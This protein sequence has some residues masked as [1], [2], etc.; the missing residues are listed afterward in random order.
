MSTAGSVAGSYAAS[1]THSLN[2]GLSHNLARKRPGS[3]N[4]AEAGRKRS[5]QRAVIRTLREMPTLGLQFSGV[6]LGSNLGSP[7]VVDVF[8]FLKNIRPPRFMRS[9]RDNTGHADDFAPCAA[10]D[11]FVQSDAKMLRLAQLTHHPLFENFQDAE[12][13]LNTDSEL[14]AMQEL[15]HKCALVFEENRHTGETN[16]HH[17]QRRRDYESK[18]LNCLQITNENM[19]LFKPRDPAVSSIFF[20]Q[21]SMDLLSQIKVWGDDGGFAGAGQCSTLYMLSLDHEGRS[22]PAPLLQVITLLSQGLR[23]AW[24]ANDCQQWPAC[25]TH[26]TELQGFHTQKKKLSG[27]RISTSDI[28]RRTKRRHYDQCLDIDAELHEKLMLHNEN[29]ESQAHVETPITQT[30]NQT[31]NIIQNPIAN[32]DKN[33]A[34]DKNDD[35]VHNVSAQHFFD[36]FLVSR[37]LHATD[38]NGIRRVVKVDMLRIH[39][40]FVGIDAIVAIKNCIQALPEFTAPLKHVLE[41]MAELLRGDNS[42]RNIDQLFACSTNDDIVDLLNENGL[43]VALARFADKNNIRLERY[44]NLDSQSRPD[45][46]LVRTFL[47]SVN[48]W[49]RHQYHEILRESESEMSKPNLKDFPYSPFIPSDFQDRNLDLDSSD[50]EPIPLIGDISFHWRSVP[51]LAMHAIAMSFI[52]NATNGIPNSE[53]RKQEM[54]SEYQ[55]WIVEMPY[56]DSTLLYFPV[57]GCD[58]SDGVYMKI[59]MQ[60]FS[61]NERLGPNNRDECGNKIIPLM[62]Q[63]T[64]VSPCI[65]QYVSSHLDVA[66]RSH[67]VCF[68]EDPACVPDRDYILDNYKKMPPNVWSLYEHMRREQVPCMEYAGENGRQ[69]M[70]EESLQ[71]CYGLRAHPFV[72]KYLE[73]VRHSDADM[74]NMREVLGASFRCFYS[75]YEDTLGMIASCCFDQYRYFA[76]YIINLDQHARKQ[77]QM[78]FA[79]INR[80]YSRYNMHFAGTGS[81]ASGLGESD[82]NETN[83]AVRLLQRKLLSKSEDHL[84]T[85]LTAALLSCNEEN[86]LAAMYET[87]IEELDIRLCWWNRLV[88]MNMSLSAAALFGYNVSNTTWGYFIQLSDLGNSMLCVSNEPVGKR[89]SYIRNSKGPSA[90]ADQTAAA[91]S[92]LNKIHG[93]KLVKSQ[94]SNLANFYATA[95]S[96]VTAK[97]TSP[98]G[99]AMLNGSSVIVKAGK[100]QLDRNVTRQYGLFSIYLEGG[101]TDAA[102]TR[103]TTELATMESFL[104][105]SGKSCYMQESNWVSGGSEHKDL[106][107]GNDLPVIERTS[108]RQNDQEP[109]SLKKGGRTKEIAAGVLDHLG[110]ALFPANRDTA[111]KNDDTADIDAVQQCSMAG[112]IRFLTEQDCQRSPLPLLLRMLLRHLAYLQRTMTIPFVDTNTGEGEYTFHLSQQRLSAHIRMSTSQIRRYYFDADETTASRTFDGAYCTSTLNPMHLQALA[113]RAVTKACMIDPSAPPLRAAARDVLHGLLICPPSVNT[114]FGSLYLWLTQAVLDINAMILACFCL[115]MAGFQR[116]CPIRVIAMAA[117]GLSAHFSKD[118]WA[119]YNSLCVFLGRLFFASRGPARDQAAT[120]ELATT[121]SLFPMTE[122]EI[123]ACFA[124]SPPSR[125]QSF[126]FQNPNQNPDQQMNDDAPDDAANKL[127]E[128]EAL[129]EQRN[130]TCNQHHTP[131]VVPAFACET[132]DLPEFIEHRNKRDDFNFGTSNT[133]LAEIFAQ[134]QSEKNEREHGKT[135]AD[136]AKRKRQHFQN[137][138]AFW[139][140]A[141]QGTRLQT[142]LEESND[143]SNRTAIPCQCSAKWYTNNMPSG[144]ENKDKPGG[145]FCDFLLLCG[146]P[147]SSSTLQLVEAI[148]APYLQKNPNLQLKRRFRDPHFHQPI[149]QLSLYKWYAMPTPK[150]TNNN[151]GIDVR[152]GMQVAWMILAQALYTKEWTGPRQTSLPRQEQQH[153]AKALEYSTVVHLRN[154]GHAAGEL[155]FMHAHLRTDKAALPREG[156]ALAL[157]NPQNKKYRPH[158][159]DADRNTFA[160]NQ[161]SAVIIPYV[162]D[163]HTTSWHA[164]VSPLPRIDED[165]G[166]APSTKALGLKFDPFNVLNKRFS[167]DIH[168]IQLHL[169]GHADVI[170]TEQ[171]GTPFAANYHVA[172]VDRRCSNTHSAAVDDIFPYPPESVAH[173]HGHHILLQRCWRAYVRANV[174]AIHT[175][176]HT[177]IHTVQKDNADTPDWIAVS[178]AFSMLPAAFRLAGDALDRDSVNILSVSLTS[179]FMHNSGIGVEMPCVFTKHGFTCTLRTDATTNTATLTPVRPTHVHL[180]Q[181]LIDEGICRAPWNEMP[182]VGDCRDVSFPLHMLNYALSHGLHFL[183][184]RSNGN[185]GIRFL[186]PTASFTASQQE[187]FDIEQLVLAPW[188]AIHFNQLL[189]C[190]TSGKLGF[191]FNLDDGYQIRLVR[192]EQFFHEFLHTEH[193]YRLTPNQ[194]QS[195]RKI[196]LLDPHS[197]LYCLNCRSITSTTT[198]RATERATERD[199]E[200]RDDL[201]EDCAFFIEQTLPSQQIVYHYYI[202]F[203]HLQHDLSLF[204]G[205]PD[206]SLEFQQGSEPLLFCVSATYDPFDPE[207]FEMFH[208]L[209]KPGETHCTVD[210]CEFTNSAEEIA[211]LEAEI[212]QL[213][214]GILG[215]RA[216]LDSNCK[217]LRRLETNM[218]AYPGMIEDHKR[219]IAKIEEQLKEERNKL[220]ASR[221]RCK[222]LAKKITRRVFKQHTLPAAKLFEPVNLVPILAPYDAELLQFQTRNSDPADDVFFACVR[223]YQSRH[224]CRAGTYSAAFSLQDHDDNFRVGL[225]HFDFITTA[226]AIFPEGSS[227]DIIC[228]SDVFCSICKQLKVRVRLSLLHSAKNG[229]MLQEIDMD[230]LPASCIEYCS[231]AADSDNEHSIHSMLDLMPPRIQTFYVLGDAESY[232]IAPHADAPKIALLLPIRGTASQVIYLP[233]FRTGKLSASPEIVVPPCIGS[234]ESKCLRDTFELDI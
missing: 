46:Q 173:M 125:R 37:F 209:H 65:A 135:D 158:A 89:Q 199:A 224:V 231:Q 8:P 30:R 200:N 189:L 198:E 50:I 27:V 68:F 146:L 74:T 22:V 160:V 28:Q 167:K 180:S 184:L 185:A 81:G 93:S 194:L 108:N 177:T 12:R 195:T 132:T 216:H 168:V 103:S 102:S 76:A 13:Y 88:D 7:R 152:I 154:M 124:L 90:G 66:G 193:M 170:Y 143:V 227:C 123:R 96:D 220:K 97:T 172:N 57:A 19:P 3:D 137:S 16:A 32:P 18:L 34:S 11:E 178:S 45:M 219:G 133:M 73:M 205:Y 161:R 206:P 61:P 136:P 202:N 190:T 4:D 77:S 23:G 191:H 134:S 38:T 211:Q 153:D 208:V 187:D 60:G 114:I 113:W 6:L 91:N 99:W 204:S 112:G 58:V 215:I 70:L 171:N 210:V 196:N 233:L 128:C 192:P 51:L 86:L 119:E 140:K 188:P 92:M 52:T 1:L 169:H 130:L 29:V 151:G 145:V 49:R 201:F 43:C 165:S 87:S 17:A 2:D 213:E 186:P 85:K 182:V 105:N 67:F 100:I 197:V 181:T 25:S 223:R 147:A 157:P 229:N 20:P 75:S 5:K 212:L 42:F 126:S 120:C 176:I 164:T 179:A 117:R 56:K 94:N 14:E 115:Q 64:M 148:M 35:V 82:T 104:G 122:T 226:R 59:D 21:Q 221:T 36:M 175:T 150:H 225:A 203:Q 207:T 217:E 156:V 111:A 222:L 80:L 149:Y 118:D 40:R 110:H 228:D 155:L 55:Q 234:E 139:K 62:M 79:N 142:T 44:H 232:D 71:Q 10:Y 121:G 83:A 15:L 101:K 72:S 33:E 78:Y 39:P 163:L 109:D 116:H 230:S 84:Q 159:Q 214:D 218:S 183:T 48:A 41:H 98:Q 127:K 166:A 24:S 9:R 47:D 129:F 53:I 138:K 69:K 63:P 54:L 131:Y 106:I 162:A 174:S 144:G 141:G 26:Y 95:G 107:K 31:Q